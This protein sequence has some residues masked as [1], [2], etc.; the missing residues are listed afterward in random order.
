MFL[1]SIR[2]RLSC[3]FF[4][5]Y[6]TKEKR[7]SLCILISLLLKVIQSQILTNCTFKDSEN[8]TYI[9][10][11]KEKKKKENKKKKKEEEE[12]RGGE[13][14]ALNMQNQTSFQF[15]SSRHLIIFPSRNS[16]IIHF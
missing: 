16:L 12:G 11:N 1:G 14:D 13:L 3:S 4:V 8:W 6:R 9:C 7:T 2:C 10:Q 5:K 15:L